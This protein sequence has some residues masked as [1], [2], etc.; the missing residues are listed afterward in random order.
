MARS[1]RQPPS[2]SRWSTSA[3]RSTGFRPSPASTPTGSGS[4]ARRSAA[5]WRCLLARSTPAIKSVIAIAPPTVTWDGGTGKSSFSFK[6]KSVPYAV[7]FGL[8]ALAQPFRDAVAARQDSRPTIPGIVA[9]A[10]ADPEIAAAIIP[11]EK[12]NGSVLIVSGTEDTQLPSVVYGELSMDRLKA[13]DFAFPYRHI[14]GEGAGHLIDV[15][16]VDRS[17][18]I[19]EG[20]GNPVAN[21]LAGEAMWPVVLEYLAPLARSRDG[22]NRSLGAVPSLRA[23]LRHSAID[24]ILPGDVRRAR[25][26]PAIPRHPRSATLALA[27]PAL[28]AAQRHLPGSR[29]PRR[30]PLE[31]GAAARRP[32]ADPAA[33]PRPPRGDERSRPRSR[34]GCSTPRC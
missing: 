18:E 32:A 15:P 17:L 26:R 16:Y 21:E 9:S 24:R 19:S 7:P 1:C 2:R 29:P 11:V 8:E 10:K 6:G 27:R 31:V 23:R 20:G 28:P 4:T 12:I 13:H 33:R 14:I 34:P 30:R 22:T 5:R 25:H 3:R